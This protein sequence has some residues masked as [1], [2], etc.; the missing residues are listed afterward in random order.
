MDLASLPGGHGTEGA[1]PTRDPWKQEL[2]HPWAALSQNWPPL[3]CTAHGEHEVALPFAAWETGMR[4][5]AGREHPNAVGIQVPLL[6]VD[7]SEPG[8]WNDAV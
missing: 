8:C 2:E 3:L 6:R 5:V 4:C 1:H 7:C